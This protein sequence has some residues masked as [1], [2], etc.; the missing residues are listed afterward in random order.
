MQKIDGTNQLN[1]PIQSTAGKS[2]NF[3]IIGG[4]QYVWG[5]DAVNSGGTTLTFARAFSA[6][7]AVMCTTQDPNEQ[8][9][10]VSAR[11]TTAVTLKQKYTGANLGVNWIAIGPA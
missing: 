5:F 6:V 8:T 1:V 4:I 11:S 3:A 2:G 9:A 7:P 10:W